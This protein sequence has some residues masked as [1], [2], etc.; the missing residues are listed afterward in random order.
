MMEVKSIGK[1]PSIVRT[2][3]WGSLALE[4]PKAAHRPR[5]QREGEYVRGG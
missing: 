4:E 2:G 5:A 1:V 3:L